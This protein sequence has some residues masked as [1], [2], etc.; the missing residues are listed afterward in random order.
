M[1]MIKSVIAAAVLAVA[2][3][4]PAMASET[5]APAKQQWSFK[6]PF[7][8][9]DRS[10]LQ[11]GFQIYKEVCSA[12]HAMRQVYFR[13]LA[14]LGYNENEIKALAA[15]VEVQDGP[16]DE[17][18]MFN[19]PG[20]PYDRFKSPFPNDNAARAANNGA[21]PPDL[22]VMTKARVHGADYLYALLT[23]YKPAP[24]SM[25]LPDGMSYNTAFAGAQIAMGAPLSEGSVT[26]ADGTK[27][28]VPQMAH[29]VVTFL[30]WAA[31]PE[32]EERKRLGLKVMLFLLL[33]T[34]VL[35]AAKRRIWANVH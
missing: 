25:K 18:Q 32:M 23:G 28:T 12:C 34:G 14:A 15:S 22:S 1:T 7:G 11:R 10:A 17:G 20:R 13:N 16:N 19:R 2:L 33:L 5:P 27:A 35:F 21:L 6:G 30:S 31:E 3:V 9:F 29:D 8:T 24:S 4:A 26:Y